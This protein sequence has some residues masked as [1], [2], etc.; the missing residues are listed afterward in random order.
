MDL[1]YAFFSLTTCDQH[2]APQ[3]HCLCQLLRK[4]LIC[5]DSHSSLCLCLG[6]WCLP[7]Q[8]MY[9]AAQIRARTRLRG[10]ASC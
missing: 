8:V 6:Q 7:A 3:G 1:R 9:V 10:C 5:G 4:P 2:P